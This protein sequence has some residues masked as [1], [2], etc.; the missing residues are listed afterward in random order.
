MA[1]KRLEGEANAGKRICVKELA[2]QLGPCMNSDFLSHFQ[3]TLMVRHPRFALA[4][5][6]KGWP[7]FTEDES[8]FGSVHKVMTLLRD[9]GERFVVLDGMDLIQRPEETVRA[10]CDSMDLKYIPE[11]LN[12]EAGCFP[13]KDRPVF[14]PFRAKARDTKG[15]GH[16][17][18]K[19]PVID[20]WLAKRIDGVM[21]YYRELEMNIMVV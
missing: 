16:V 20:E 11:A 5:L 10:W 3:S 4:S 18:V 17:E 2:F 19:E 21:P 9:I 13:W 15:L 14:D 12:W 8:G 7:D 6:Q 1:L